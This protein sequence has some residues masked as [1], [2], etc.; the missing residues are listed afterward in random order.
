MMS[1]HDPEEKLDLH[2]PLT[3]GAW[4]THPLGAEPFEPHVYLNQERGHDESRIEGIRVALR[5]LHALIAALQK[6]LPVVEALAS[7]DTKPK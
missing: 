1:P 4:R 2:W 3:I 6:R 5:D 7:L